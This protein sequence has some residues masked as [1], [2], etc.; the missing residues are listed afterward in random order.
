MLS[1]EL[2]ADILMTLNTEELGSDDRRGDNEKI[3]E[4]MKRECERSSTA[5]AS[6][7]AFQ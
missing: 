5:K 4:H 2:P 3:R 1:G 6:T 7:D